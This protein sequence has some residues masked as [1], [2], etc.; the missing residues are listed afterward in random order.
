MSSGDR[1][2]TTRCNRV[3]RAISLQ[4]LPDQGI[5][6]IRE[7]HWLNFR[8]QY[9]RTGPKPAYYKSLTGWRYAQGPN[10]NRPSNEP[11]RAQNIHPIFPEFATF[12]GGRSPQC[13]RWP[14][15]TGPRRREHRVILTNRKDNDRPRDVVCDRSGMFHPASSV[16]AGMVSDKAIR[17]RCR[18]SATHGRSTEPALLSLD[19]C[20]DL[21]SFPKPP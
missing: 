5:N 14:R 1:Q 2:S 3:V 10:G 18:K 19:R 20:H 12:S 21:L 6:R 17:V 11:S 9:C 13:M 4:A 16:G 15:F 7:S 8:L